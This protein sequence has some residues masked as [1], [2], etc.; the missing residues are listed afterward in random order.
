MKVPLLVVVCLAVFAFT[1]NS[2]RGSD[3]ELDVN[4]TV[5]QNFISTVGTVGIAGGDTTSIQ[6][7]YPG[8][9]WWGPVPYPCIAW[10]SCSAGYNYSVSA[11]NV[12]V[13][14]IPG[15]IPFSGDASANA[16]AELCGITVSA[17]YSPAFNGLLSASWNSG[18]SQLWFAMQSLNIEIYVD[19]LGYHITLGYVDVSSH[20]PN[21][22]YKMSLPLA[23]VI[24]LGSPINKNITVTLV[25]PTVAL[26]AG[27][28]RFTT[29]LKFTSP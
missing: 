10:T 14:V 23:Q 1:A 12:H 19:L 15:A 29:D 13:S 16:S 21:P 26:L 18:A 7:P 27:D 22:L 6:I 11:S 8:I 4:Q 9:C 28:V 3:V 17:S 20:I 2:A 5:L 24:P 25:N